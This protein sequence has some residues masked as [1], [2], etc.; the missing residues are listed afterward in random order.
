MKD[1]SINCERM[2]V[3]YGQAAKTA[4]PREGSFHLVSSAVSL[5][6][7]FPEGLLIL[8]SVLSV[9]GN[10]LDS[11]FGRFFAQLI[12]VITFVR[13]ESLGA[14]LRA[15]LSAVVN[16]N[17]FQG[18]IYKRDLSRRGRVDMASEWNTLTVDRHHPLSSLAFLGFPNSHAPF[19][20]GA[21]LPSMNASSQSRTCLPS[22][23]ARNVRHISSHRSSSSRN[24]KRLLHVLPLGKGAGASCQR[25][26]VL[27]IQSMPSRT[28]RLPI[29]GRP[30]LRT[31]STYGNNG[32]ILAHCS[33]V[34]IG[35]VCLIGSPP[36]SLIPKITQKYKC[37]L[38][39]RAI[40]N[41]WKFET[42]SS[43]VFLN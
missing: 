41:G 8:L 38:E 3:H 2:I 20:P 36:M 11:P 19:F 32:S 15:A 39:S 4:D 28:S 5:T 40:S 43:V 9:R 35:L 31:R 33:S 37:L 29:R 25:P 23:S 17:V 14:S 30:L 34:N 22:S 13:D 27:K 42:T 7:R 21:K 10:E 26:P 24:S 12:A 18:L 6:S 1:L 16:S